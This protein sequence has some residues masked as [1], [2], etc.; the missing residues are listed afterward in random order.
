MLCESG[1]QGTSTTTKKQAGIVIFWIV[2]NN[3]L[4]FDRPELCLQG[5]SIRSK[6]QPAIVILRNVFWPS[7]GTIEILKQKVAFQEPC[8]LLGVEV[9]NEP[10]AWT[11]DFQPFTLPAFVKIYVHFTLIVTRV[12]VFSSKLRG[13]KCSNRVGAWIFPKVD[14]S[15][16]RNTQK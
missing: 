7:Q 6:K 15:P 4:T 14:A 2:F 11:L 12:A 13:S 3:F 16:R 8:K 5:R 9:P 1:L 10:G